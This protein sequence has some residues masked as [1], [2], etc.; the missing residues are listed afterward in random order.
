MIRL[1]DFLYTI[2]LGHPFHKC[3]FDYENPESID[4]DKHTYYSCKRKGC[5]FV[6]SIK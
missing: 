1:L 3:D 6:T 2:F 5:H 4:R